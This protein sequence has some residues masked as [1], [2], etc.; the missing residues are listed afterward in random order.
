MMSDCRL[1]TAVKLVAT[2]MKVRRVVE[3]GIKHPSG[4]R[5]YTGGNLR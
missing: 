2:A 3:V 4:L 1:A 5:R